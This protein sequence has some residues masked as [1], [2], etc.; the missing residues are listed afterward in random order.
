[1][2]RI[3]ARPHIAPMQHTE[4]QRNAS[5]FHL[6][7]YAMCA[8]TSAVGV[9]HSIA[10]AVERATPEPTSLRFF[11]VKRKSFAPRGRLALPS[12][13]LPGHELTARH[14]ASSA[15]VRSHALGA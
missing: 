3:D 2:R 12:R 5:V 9:N 11:S 13:F 14:Q 8:T 1:M 7:G 6:I 10:N 4:P 15:S